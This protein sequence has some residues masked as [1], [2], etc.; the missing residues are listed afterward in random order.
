[1]LPIT[2]NLTVITAPD[3]APRPEMAGAPFC[4]FPPICPDRPPSVRSCP[5]PLCPAGVLLPGLLP[6]FP[7]VR[8]GAGGGG[9]APEP[10]RTMPQPGAAD[11]GAPFPGKTKTHPTGSPP[12]RVSSQIQVCGKPACTAQGRRSP[13]GKGAVRRCLQGRGGITSPRRAWLPRTGCRP[14]RRGRPP[15]CCRGPARWRGCT[16]GAQRRNRG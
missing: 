12:S 5:L 6:A 15:A 1:M 16:D 10:P 2:S 9:P 3:F 13:C 4:V 8:G 7:A 11:K 14:G